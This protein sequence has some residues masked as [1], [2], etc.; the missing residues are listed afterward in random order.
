[1]WGKIAVSISSVPTSPSK[2]WNKRSSLGGQQHCHYYQ[3]QFLSCIWFSKP[4][5]WD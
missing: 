5:R 4:K 1:M 2:R 3:L